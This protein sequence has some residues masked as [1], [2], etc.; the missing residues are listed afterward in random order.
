[1]NFNLAD[2]YNPPFMA[3]PPLKFNVPAKWV[4]LV[5]L[6]L[7][8]LGLLGNL[9]STLLGTVIGAIG[10]IGGNPFLL[11]LAVSAI[12]GIIGNVYGIMGGW[13]MFQENPAGR[14]Q[15]ITGY[16]I[17]IGAGLIGVF[18]NLTHPAVLVAGIVGWIVGVAI[19]AVGWYILLMCRF[20]G[21]PMW[22]PAVFSVGMGVPGAGGGYPPQQGGYPPQQGYP[23]QTP[24]Y[25]PQTP[26]AQ[27]PGY[28]PQQPPPGQPPQQ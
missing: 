11:L 16:A 18:S 15:A 20:P 12:V 3:N 14:N 5:V 6:I 13:K 1:M 8:A 2:L 22:E 25:P 17:G 21:D 10:S 26:P 4:G 9:L 24:G 27:T 19:A 23:P 28:P 7:S